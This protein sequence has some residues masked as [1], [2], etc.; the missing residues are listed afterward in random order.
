[1]AGGGSRGQ[2]IP[3]LDRTLPSVYLAGHLAHQGHRHPVGLGLL[4]PVPEQT[5]SVI[6]PTG[7][8]PC[9]PSVVGVLAWFE[10]PFLIDDHDGT[11]SCFFGLRHIER[12]GAVSPQQ[13]DV[14]SDLYVPVHAQLRRRVGRPD[15]DV[16]AIVCQDDI[17]PGYHFSKGADHGK[18]ADG[19]I[20]KL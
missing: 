3:Y 10:R 4:L 13:A 20:S 14:A 18:V 19:I 6:S 5:S 16:A 11:R 2:Q 12:F 9:Y 8:D 7:D 15:A 1:M 17:A